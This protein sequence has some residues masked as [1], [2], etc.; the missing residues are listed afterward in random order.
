MYLS[1]YISIYADAFLPFLH[2]I[3]MFVLE[4]VLKYFVLFYLFL[5]FSKKMIRKCIE[6]EETQ[7]K[8]AQR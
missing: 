5:H 7:E 4:Y 2:L 3:C 8:Y 6:K 1:Q